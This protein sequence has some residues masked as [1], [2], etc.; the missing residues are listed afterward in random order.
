MTQGS[1]VEHEGTAKDSPNHNIALQS[2]FQ[3]YQEP[4]TVI[5]NY[6]KC[7]YLLEPKGGFFM[8]FFVFLNFRRVQI[9]VETPFNYRLLVSF[10][11]GGD[12]KGNTA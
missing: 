10:N 6:C 11:L 2:E 5:T 12:K 7:V 9:N 8:F 3:T 1:H 4:S